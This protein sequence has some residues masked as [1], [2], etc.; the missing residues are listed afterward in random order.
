METYRKINQWTS[1]SRDMVESFKRYYNN[2]FLDA[3]RQEAYNLFLGNYIFARGQP[4]LWDLSTDYYLHHSDPRAWAAKG[5]ESY[6][7]WFTKESLRRR[8]LPPVPE[9]SESLEK[10]ALEYFDDYWLEYYRPLAVS[11]F[12]KIF[13]YRMNSTLRYIP[14]KST[15]E[16]RYDL[17]PFCVRTGADNEQ[18]EKKRSKKG[19]DFGNRNNDDSSDDTSSQVSQ[20]TNTSKGMSIQRWLQPQ[21]SEKT[22]YQHHGILKDHVLPPAELTPFDTFIPADKTLSAQWTLD[23][24]VDNALN[25]S[26]TTGEAAEYERYVSHPLNLPLV[27]S[28]DTPLNPNAD[29]VGYVNSVSAEAVAGLHSTE[30]D[31]VD[32]AEFLTVSENPLTVGEADAPKKRYKAYR[33]WLKGKSLFKQSRVES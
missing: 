23:Q 3:Q 18:L 25:P 1:H 16:G 17:S 33:Q 2:S 4:M 30:E 20:A 27:V 14:F 31:L 10:R 21:L 8:E 7:R 5:R 13:S 24:F 19:V 32:Y 12:M 29:L 6:T 26:V 22:D 9:C 11:S 15:Q 28:T